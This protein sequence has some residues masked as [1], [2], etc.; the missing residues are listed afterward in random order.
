MSCLSR[1]SGAKRKSGFGAVRAAF[2]PSCVKTLFHSQK[3]RAIRDDPLR[4]DGLSISGP[5]VNPGAR[6]GRAEGPER[7]HDAHNSTSSSRPDCYQER[8]D[9]DDVHYA[10]EVVGEYI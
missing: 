7:S 4:H 5:G 3:M 9:A 8:L 6:S 10:R 1:L 2:D